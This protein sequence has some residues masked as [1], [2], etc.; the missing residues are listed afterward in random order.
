MISWNQAPAGTFGEEERPALVEDRVEL[1]AVA[2]NCA[3]R[4][5]PPKNGIAAGPGRRAIA[6]ANKLPSRS[7]AE[8]NLVRPP[9][10]G[11]RQWGGGPPHRSCGEKRGPR[12]RPRSSGPSGAFRASRSERR[13]GILAAMERRDDFT[14]QGQPARVHAL[15]GQHPVGDLPER[16]DRALHEDHLHHVVAF[17]LHPVAADAL[18]DLLALDAGGAFPA[19]PAWRAS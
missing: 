15:A 14:G 12:A 1:L 18:L 4:R 5:A 19:G 16:P 10:P 2:G 17:E 3:G 7:P 13:I 6:P 11:R 9:R 8:V